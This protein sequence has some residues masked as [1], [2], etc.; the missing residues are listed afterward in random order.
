[1]IECH[2]DRSDTARMGTT[3]VEQKISNAKPDTR[4][5]SK[6]PA[7]S[8]N[9]LLNFENNSRQE[10]KDKKQKRITDVVFKPLELKDSREVA[11][12]GIRFTHALN[13]Y[14]SI[15]DNQATLRITKEL[16]AQIKSDQSFVA[17]EG[18]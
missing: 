15:E 7:N 13:P 1:M 17:F 2:C 9:N 10:E 6:Y 3:T 11:G 5:L 8:F 12:S 16:T 18:S 4:Y 14:D